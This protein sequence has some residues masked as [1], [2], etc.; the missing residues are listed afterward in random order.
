MEVDHR[1]LRYCLGFL[2]YEN[3]FLWK[4]VEKR[5]DTLFFNKDNAEFIIEQIYMEYLYASF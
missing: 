1:L 4:M 5:L 2:K 3:P